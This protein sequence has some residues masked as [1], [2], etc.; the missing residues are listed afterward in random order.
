MADRNGVRRALRCAFR[1][2]HGGGPSRPLAAVARRAA[3][4]L[5]LAAAIVFVLP[6]LPGAGGAAQADVLVSNLGKGDAS[7]SAVYATRSYGQSFRTGS[8]PAGYVLD[9]IDLVVSDAPTDASKVTVAIHRALSGDF[10][11]AEHC[12]LTTPATLSNGTRTFTA[13]SCLLDADSTYIVVVE[14][15]STNQTD[16]KLKDTSSS[17]EDVKLTDW[18]IGDRSILTQGS[19]WVSGTTHTALKIRVN[20]KVRTGVKEITVT[21]SPPAVPGGTYFQGDTITFRVTFTGG[22]NFANAF[23]SLKVDV[24][25]A[26]KTIGRFRARSDGGE[27]DYTVESGD[28]DASGVSIPEDGL[29]LT[30]GTITDTDGDAVDLAHPAY[31]FADHKVDGVDRLGCPAPTGTQVWTGNLTVGTGTNLTGYSSSTS[32]GSLDDRDFTLDGTTYTIDEL[33]HRTRGNLIFSLTSSLASRGGLVLHVAHAHQYRLAGATYISSSHSYNSFLTTVP[34]SDG[35]TVCLLLE[36][37]PNRE[38]TGGIGISGTARVG[39]TLSQ[40]NMG[41]ADA[42]G[43]NNARASTTRQWKRV[44]ADGE[45][46][47][48]DVGTD[49]TYTLTA[50]DEGKRILL[51]F[52]FTDDLGYRETFTSDAFPAHGTVAA[53]PGGIAAITG[54]VIWQA[55]MTAASHSTNCTGFRVGTGGSLS[56]RDIR[57]KEHHLEIHNLCQISGAQFRATFRSS[58]RPNRDLME[59]NESF[60]FGGT[61]KGPGAISGINTVRY[62][63]IANSGF[64]VTAGQTYTLTITTTEPGAPMGITAEAASSTSIRL[65]WRPPLSIGGSA[66]TGYEYRVKAKT[67]SSWGSWTTAGST[68]ASREQVVSGLDVSTVYEFQMRAKNS[69]GDGLWSDVVEGKTTAVIACSAASENNRLWTADLT[70]GTG[71]AGGTMTYGWKAGN[72]Y[73]GD[74]LTATEFRFEGDRYQLEGVFVGG[75]QFLLDFGPNAVGDIATDATRD[76]LTLHVGDDTF[77]LGDGYF[78]PESHE[79]IWTGHDL[80]W[81]PGDRICLALTDDRPAVDLV[82]LAVVGNLPAADGRT[83]RLG[84]KILSRVNFDGAITSTGNAPQLRVTVGGAPK[85]A[86]CAVDSSN[87]KVLRCLYTV[88]EGDSGLID[89]PANGLTVP[90]GGTLAA[91]LAFDADQVQLQDPPFGAD[92]VRPTVQAANAQNN[93]LVLRWSEELTSV[94][95]QGGTGGF[96]LSADAGGDPPPVE[97]VIVNGKRVTLTL[98]VEV[99]TNRTYRLHYAPPEAEADRVVKDAAGNAAEAFRDQPVRF[100]PAPEGPP[101]TGI[102][103]TTTPNGRVLYDGIRQQCHRLHRDLRRAGDGEQCPGPEGHRRRSRERRRLRQFQRIGGAFQILDSVHP[104]RDRRREHPR[105]RHPA[106]DRRHHHRRALPRAGR[107]RPRLDRRGGGVRGGPRH[108]ARRL[109]K[110]DRG[111]LRGLVGRG[112]RPGLCRR[113]AAPGRGRGGGRGRACRDEGRDD[114]EGGGARGAAR[115]GAGRRARGPRED[116]GGGGA[117]LRGAGH[118]EPAAHRRVARRQALRH[119]AER[120]ARR[121]GGCGRDPGRGRRG[122]AGGPGAAVG[123]GPQA[124]A[125]WRLSALPRPAPVRWGPR[126]AVA[127]RPAG[128]TSQRRWSSSRSRSSMSCRYW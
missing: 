52:G 62:F 100:G 45:S 108:A 25:N 115:R 98:S 65:R 94:S 14:H 6:V 17:G 22:V 75:S 109:H 19:T 121:R 112:A 20:G 120:G 11:G 107:S 82:F 87:D 67:A 38:A 80:S 113:R 72:D 16:F 70:V 76:G 126:R 34:W 102:A 36:R 23:M 90:E 93:L 57:Y 8:D 125:S 55:Q 48:V 41:I 18:G 84:E 116:G 40:V 1:P 49:T 61:R 97:H 3:V 37:L 2:G 50:D 95:Y 32:V 74:R 69:S 101:I 77:K 13:T 123:L 68:G 91:K 31:A 89:I 33:F 54:T 28:M 122:G 15:D 104:P 43:A 83:Y 117:A 53:A 86:A 63:E 24:G 47:P 39:E 99:D 81:F 51:E 46:N 118:G 9:S 26:Q 127:G 110:R 105:E 42:D 10:P 12:A 111:R 30:A 114:G 5:L 103:I 29:V 88:S 106:A 71:M 79:V 128:G 60:W 35:D 27:F 96:T 59:S 58:D 4:A 124:V 7:G 73:D 64:T 78:V 92:G 119:R 66:I 21:S 56:E 44:D 85:Q